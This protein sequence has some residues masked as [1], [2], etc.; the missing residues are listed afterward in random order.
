MTT[1]EAPGLT[2]A[3]AAA[4]E[5]ARDHLL[6]LQSP[7]G[8]WKAE[9]ETHVTMD[10]EDL[11]L[12]Q[13]LGIRSDADTKDAA[14]WI[15]AQQ[16]EDGTWANFHGG[17]GDLSTTIEAYIALRLAGDPVDADHMRRAAKFARD[18]GG[19]EGSRVFT[20]IWLALVGQGSWDDLPVMPPAL[21]FL[22]S[23]VPLNV[24]DWACWARQTI[25]PLTVLGSVRPVRELPVDLA[26]LRSGVLPADDA[27]GW[28]RAFNTLDRVL[29]VY[30][31]APVRPLRRAALRRAADWII[32]R[33]EADG[34]WGGIQPPWVYS[35]MA[36]NVLGY[37]L[38]H[39]V[40]KRGLD[41]LER[42][43][44]RDEKG[45]RLEACQSPV[46]DTVLAMNALGD[47]GAAPDDP[48]LLRAGR[49]IVGEEVRGPG[50]WSVR[51]P[52]TPPGGWA[53]EFDNDV[54][55]D[56]D[57]TAEA[58][59]AL[60][61]TA[62][63]E[64]SEPIER[65]IRWQ[66]GMASRDGGFGAFDADN[67]RELCTKL[68]FCDFGAVIDPP[69]AD[70]TAHVV[71]ALAKEGLAETDVVKRAVVWL[72][73]AQEADGSWFGR[74]GANHVYGTGGVVPAL[75]AAGVRPEKPAIRRAVAWLEEH[76]NPDGG[77]GEDLRSYDDPAWIGRGESTP[78][79][80][81]WALLALLA[82]GERTAAVDAGVRWLVENQRPD[83][84]WDED[85]FTGTGFPGDFYI[86]YHLYRLVF[87]ISAL[88]RYLGGAA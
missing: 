17:P 39:P 45:R 57:D 50:D 88:G 53:F 25:V 77:W 64:A 2:G 13:F 31:R 81:A 20:R 71:E 58:I 18:A 65:A 37:D 59:L 76:Q 61:K 56:T 16:R 14:R 63:P 67:T 30:E 82:A 80:T 54:Y 12:P 74:W 84:N 78:S 35:L 9:L 46:W 27:K 11:L 21:M 19:I 29:H 68:P 7:E 86:N 83:G 52:D 47:A 32:A 55:P 49:W 4:V 60:R 70:V 3:A 23:R 66:N 15:R 87:P 26:E 22:P 40:V 43:T 5:A 51:R 36:L 6:G 24:Y 69:S 10:A 79:Q 73:K 85:Q 8:W 62:L 44:I 41:G 48:A 72:L 38:D 28:G 75:I 33:Q 34:C 42:F 1:T